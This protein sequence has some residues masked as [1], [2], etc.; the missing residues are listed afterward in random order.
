MACPEART[1]I[2]RRSISSADL[3]PEVTDQSLSERPAINDTSL[4]TTY[5]DHSSPVR[6]ARDLARTNVP[7]ARCGFGGEPVLRKPRPYSPDW[8]RD[9]STY[10]GCSSCGFLL[11]RLSGPA[12]NRPS[13]ISADRLPDPAGLVRDRIQP[14]LEG[15]PADELAG[16]LERVATAA[17]AEHG[18][19]FRP[20][21]GF[22]FLWRG[23][24]WLVLTLAGDRV[25]IL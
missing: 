1:P 11:A 16:T 6:K 12:A 9:R 22:T 15:V 14:E 7:C 13:D 20:G 23:E 24:P 21:S 18:L 2:E 19:A 17:A 4:V 5:P 10:F 8:G 3:F 25:V